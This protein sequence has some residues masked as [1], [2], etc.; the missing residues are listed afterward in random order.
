MRVIGTSPNQSGE[1]RGVRFYRVPGH[2][3]VS[4]DLHPGIAQQFLNIPSI[5]AVY[6]GPELV[7]LPPRDEHDAGCLVEA[8]TLHPDPAKSPS[9][10]GKDPG[11]NPPDPPSPLVQS[12]EDGQPNPPPSGEEQALDQAGVKDSDKTPPSVD[13]DDAGLS[14]NGGGKSAGPKKGKNK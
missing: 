9:E 4:E 11:A 7:F 10:D 13:G 3:M 12:Q 1:C 2:G 5:Y 8:S 14:Q 6:D